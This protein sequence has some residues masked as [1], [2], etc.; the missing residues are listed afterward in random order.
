M[1]STLLSNREFSMGPRFREDD[2]VGLF[3]IAGRC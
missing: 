2:V 3:T 1:L